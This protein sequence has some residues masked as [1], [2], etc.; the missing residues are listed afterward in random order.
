[1]T[2]GT[3]GRIGTEETINR[4]N[5]TDTK[6]NSGHTSANESCQVTLLKLVQ[7][8]PTS[9]TILQSSQNKS[10]AENSASLADRLTSTSG[11]A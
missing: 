7:T 1:M 4:I 5:T 10:H 8:T 3:A 2:S 9:T 11:I 6:I